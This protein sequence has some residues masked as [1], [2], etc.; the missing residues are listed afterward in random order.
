MKRHL[1]LLVLVFICGLARAASPIEYVIQAKPER[2][3]TDLIV[4]ARW[5]AD[6]GHPFEVEVPKDYYGSPDLSQLVA[7]F[8]GLEGTVATRVEDLHRRR[9]SPSANGKVAVRYRMAYRPEI[10]DDASFAPV[11][12]PRQVQVFGCQW[13]LRIGRLDEPRKTS[14]R[15]KFPK[16]WISY[17]TLVADPASIS[18]TASYLDLVSSVVGMGDV[19]HKRFM[20]KGKPLDVYVARGFALKDQDIFQKIDAVVNMQR[21][22]FNDFSQPFY[23]IPLSVRPDNIAGTAV[24]NGF[25]CFLKADSTEPQVLGLLSHEMLHSW[26]PAKMHV[27]N[28]GE[29][30]RW[31]WEWFDEGF[32]EYFGRKVLLDSKSISK[33]QFVQ[34][35]NRDLLNI[36][37]NPAKN[38]TYDQVKADIDAGRFSVAHKKLSYYRG[39]VIAA[40]WDARITARSAGKRSLSDAIR[41]LYKLAAK[42][43]GRLTQEQ[44]YAFFAKE[45]IDAKRDRET[46]ILK[47]ETIEVEPLAA[48]VGFRLGQ[49]SLPVYETGFDLPASLREKKIVGVK[50]GSSAERAGLREGMH[51]VMVSNSNRFGNAWD[52]KKPLSVWVEVGGKPTRIDYQPLG[53][54]RPVPQFVP[55]R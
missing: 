39:A 11:A 27:D 4:T 28:P 36:A 41:D 24:R 38:K 1:S 52:S 42:T 29:T 55:N 53:P 37:D 2:N 51:L 19:S 50:P 15:L 49:P 26:I 40:N 31:E 7:S 3:R 9:L 17:T 10:L 12:N 23:V 18:V 47:G 33:L 13:M 5:Q 44:F 14:I 21:S 22:W 6:D 43:S 35:L 32:A 20:I 16:D 25:V 30:E 48:G 45:R 34:L 54:A 8:E 46:Y